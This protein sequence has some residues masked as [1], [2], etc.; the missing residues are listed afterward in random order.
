M[1]MSSIGSTAL[2][3]LIA[4]ANTK[5]FYVLGGVNITNVRNLEFGAIGDGTTND[6]VA[7]Q[8]AIDTAIAAGAR[9]IYFPNGTYYVTALT[10]DDQVIFF[11]DNAS[12]V[13]GYLGTI[14]QFGDTV[15]ETTFAAL[16]ADVAQRAY[17]VMSAPYNATGDGVTNDSTAIQ[18]ALDAAN[19]AGGG[20]VF[21]P[22]PPSKYIAA[23]LFVYSNTILQGAGWDTIIEQ[24]E[25]VTATDRLINLVGSTVALTDN[26]VGI[27]IRDI[28]IKGTVDVAA[29]SEQRHLLYMQGVSDIL[30][31]NVKFVGWRGDA[32]YISTGFGLQHHNERITIRNCHFDGV[33]KDNRNAITLMDCNHL[34]IDNCYFVNCT[35]ADMPGAIDIEPNSSHAW[36]VIRNII[37]TNNRF[38]NIG[39]L[40]GAIN[41]FVGMSQTELTTPI[42]NITIE[43]NDIEDVVQ[44]FY[45]AQ[46]QTAD[47]TSASEGLNIKVINNRVK[48]ATVKSFWV[49]GCKDVTFERNEFQDC[50]NGGYVGW[51]NVYQVCNNIKFINNTLRRVG[52]SSGEGITVYSNTRLDF[53][54]NIFDDV[55]LAAGTYGVGIRF[56]TGTTSYV[57]VIRNEFLEPTGISTG[58]IIKDAGHTFTPAGNVQKYNNFTTLGNSFVADLVDYG[59]TSSTFTAE[60]LPDSY[61]VGMT[62]IQITSLPGMP[63]GFQKGTIVTYKIS[64]FTTNREYITQ[65][66]Y[67]ANI[68][69]ASL[70]DNYTR[71]SED[72]TNAWGAWHKVV[73]TAVANN[74]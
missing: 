2:S 72:A 67:P 73:G 28:Q 4:L 33:N 15:S 31:D 69:G 1:S 12:F 40:F 47:I 10:G 62:V 3:R 19:T 22:K 30:V 48:N 32:C 51:L 20:I 53:I 63:V 35:R 11:G 39:G 29:F 45:F 27:V 38:K 7:V 58:A 41:L 34:L 42:K 64:L 5:A 24:V 13:G 17:N 18:A 23:N 52:T 68:G 26:Q 61:N 57:R 44:A 70:T 71:R 8:L 6:T 50:A 46:T 16:E 74:P 65:V 25:T 56:A 14:K 66:L 36:V 21:F 49:Y 37:I 59:Y 55:G 9:S 43:N 60:T 54:G